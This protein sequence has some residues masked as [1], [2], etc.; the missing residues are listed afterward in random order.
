MLETNSS[1]LNY[2]KPI[3]YWVEAFG[4]Y[5][6]SILA[7]SA[8]SWALASSM[9]YLFLSSSS[10]AASLSAIS[11]SLCFLYISSFSCQ[12]RST[13]RLCSSSFI[14]LQWAFIYSIQS[15]SANFFIIYSLNSSSIL[16]SSNSRSF[17][18]CSWYALARKRSSLSCCHF[19]SSHLSFSQ[20]ISSYS[21]CCN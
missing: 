19:A 13:S 18:T 10:L 5:S 11:I 7:C 16:Y 4:W 15:S 1:F 12:S 21:S 17:L 14:L 20:S 6:F 9:I 8:R 2:L 3:P